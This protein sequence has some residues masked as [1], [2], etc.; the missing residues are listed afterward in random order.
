MK[1][2]VQFSSPEAENLFSNLQEVK[3]SPAHDGS[4]QV[5]C[6]LVTGEFSQ[7]TRQDSSSFNGDSAE[8]EIAF[9]H[10]YNMQKYSA[11]ARKTDFNLTYSE[12]REF[13]GEDIP[14]RR[15]NPRR[16]MLRLDKNRPIEV[17]NI[18]VG[19]PLKPKARIKGKLDEAK[20]GLIRGSGKKAQDLADE[21]GV[22][23][24]TIDLVRKGKVWA[25]VA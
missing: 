24:A 23:R 21:F 5:K 22:T 18:R 25:D 20:V 1:I 9:R 3:L 17:G 10:R 12:W 11:T 6:R 2:Y 14:Y 13:W 16:M 8:E 15:G 4:I 7:D 19:G